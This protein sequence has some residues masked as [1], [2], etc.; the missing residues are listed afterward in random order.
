MNDERGR[1]GGPLVHGFVSVQFLFNFRFNARKWNEMNT[2]NAP[3]VHSCWNHQISFQFANWIEI[4]W[5]KSLVPC[6]ASSIQ[7]SFT[8]C[9]EIELAP[10]RVIIAAHLFAAS[11]L[12]CSYWINLTE[13]KLI[14]YFTPYCYNINEIKLIKLLLVW[15]I[16]WIQS[17]RPAVSFIKFIRQLINHSFIFSCLPLQFQFKLH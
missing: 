17:I 11:W 5:L 3:F 13:F 10:C 6:A 1:Q 16:L 7:L 8:E 4:D 15:L 9:N 12:R 2:T 14:K